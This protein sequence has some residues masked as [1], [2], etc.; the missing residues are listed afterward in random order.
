MRFV[1]GLIRYS[2]IADDIIGGAAI[3]IENTVFTGGKIFMISNGVLKGDLRE[4]GGCTGNKRLFFTPKRDFLPSC[5]VLSLNP[6]DGTVRNCFAQGAIFQ[7]VVQRVIL[8][9]S[10][11]DGDARIL[12]QIIIALNSPVQKNEN[13]GD[14]EK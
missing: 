12:R 5:I 4:G 1:E 3:T 10:V 13:G 11:F 9:I 14:G 2:E 6:W 8:Y 7:G